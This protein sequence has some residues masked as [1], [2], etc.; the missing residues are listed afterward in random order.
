MD[1]MGLL[2]GALMLALLWL[3]LF[4]RL[5][6]R[7]RGY[8]GMVL[9]AATI[10]AL[11]LLR[12]RGFSG[13]LIPIVELREI[14]SAPIAPASSSPQ[15]KDTPALP[16]TTASK[17]SAE[18]AVAAS[19]KLASSTRVQY[20]NYPQFLGPERNG[21]VEGIKLARDWSAQPPRLIWR[22]PVGAGWSAFAVRNGNAITQ[23]QRGEHEA[24]VCYELTT[25]K[26]RWQHS[27]SAKYESPLAGN[28]PRATPTI[29]RDLVY[30]VGG[31]GRLN[32]LELASGKKL[33]S[34]DLLRD[35]GAQMNEWGVACS[36]LVWDS[37]LIVSVGAPQGKSLVA[38]H[39]KTGA[40]VWSAGDERTGYGSP[41]V[42][43][44]AGVPQIL[45]FNRAKILAHAT[46][47]GEILWEQSWPNETQ[48]VA[49]PV[50][51]PNDRVF[52]STGYGIGGKLFQIARDEQEFW[53]STLVWETTNLKAKFANVVVRENFVYGLDD[54]ILVCLDLDDGQRKWKRGRYGHGQLI[55]VDDL[56]LIQ[57]ESGEVFLVEANP[58][59]HVE[60]G[61]IPALEGKTWNNPALAWPYLLVRN[62]R[63]AACYELAP[64]RP[65]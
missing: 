50:V 1:T 22:K 13:D 8:A 23:E 46:A 60:L 44:I 20:F 25:G 30:T 17:I 59:A 18:A 45:I 10:A 16:E 57:A 21:S 64:A 63:E 61:S 4:S 54:G 26:E 39:A 38:Y 31:T 37:L 56:L 32:C 34:H 3:L 33:W 51:L 58:N 40:R 2:G 19:P 9:L 43:T 41:L 52:A 7:R 6:R 42:A 14:S 12:F 27:D 62:D 36:P 47:S 24:A 35:H 55:L 11:A 29:T 5:S 49:Q 28:G 65:L 48:C 15:Q 53:R